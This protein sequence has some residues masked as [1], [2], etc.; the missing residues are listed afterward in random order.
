MTQTAPGFAS[1]VRGSTAVEYALIA[2]VASIAAL[3]GLRL[4]GAS[5]GRLYASVVA[6]IVAAIGPG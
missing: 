5:A 3:A 4:F 2:G 6:T 1:D